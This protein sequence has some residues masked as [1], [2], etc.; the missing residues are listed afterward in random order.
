[1][2]DPIRTAI[3]VPVYIIAPLFKVSKDQG[4]EPYR[5]NNSGGPMSEN[6]TVHLHFG[7]SLFVSAAIHLTA[8]NGSTRDFARKAI[9]SGQ[10][11]DDPETSTVILH[12]ARHRFFV[13]PRS[14]TLRQ[15]FEGVKWPR[16]SPIPFQDL[17]RAP[18][19]RD[20]EEDG[21]ELNEGWFMNLYVLPNDGMQT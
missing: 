3:A 20:F 14:T 1:L 2:A 9:M 5:T 8:S 4:R 6:D 19:I 17:R 18:R 13:I 7:D 15:I 21:V 10:D 16:D 12:T 11:H